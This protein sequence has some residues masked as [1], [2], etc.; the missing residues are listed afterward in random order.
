[1]TPDIEAIRKRNNAQQNVYCQREACPQFR[2]A[3]VKA[4]IDL[5]LT[6]IERL[7]SGCS[8][9]HHYAVNSV[10][11]GEEVSCRCGSLRSGTEKLVAEI[12]ITRSQ[13]RYAAVRSAA[14]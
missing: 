3:H 6:E 1:M 12:A 4:D 5:L 10:V 14:S 9:D 2:C 11:E 7:T 13:Q 8:I